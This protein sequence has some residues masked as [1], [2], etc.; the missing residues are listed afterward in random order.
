MAL[1]LRNLWACP[2]HSVIER[3][4]A[5]IL[6]PERPAVVPSKTRGA[7]V[8]RVQRAKDQA[9]AAAEGSGST[10]AAMA[11]KLFNRVVRI[12]GESDYAYW[13]VLTYLPDLQWCHVAPLEKRGT[14]PEGSGASAGRP[15]WMTVSEEEGGEIDVGAGRCHIMRVRAHSPFPST[16][17][18]ECKRQSNPRCCAA[19]GQGGH[20][21]THRCLLCCSQAIEMR[22]TKENADEEEWDI[23]GQE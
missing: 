4:R 5:G 21:L 15:R 6:V 16:A 8:A 11:P 3:T 17:S 14:F 19:C 12:D 1:T 22:Q 2:G 9:A 18:C 7:I 13:Y 10:A 23:L 20:R